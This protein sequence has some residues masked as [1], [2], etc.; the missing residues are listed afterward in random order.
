MLKG[1][2]LRKTIIGPGRRGGAVLWTHT[3]RHTHTNGWA[4]RRPGDDAE[5][6]EE[7][8]EGG[9][10]DV[11][12]VMRN[13]KNRNERSLTFITS[14]W[15]DLLFPPAFKSYLI[16]SKDCITN[17][18]TAAQRSAGSLSE[19]KGHWP[20]SA[21]MWGFIHRGTHSYTVQSRCSLNGHFGLILPI[22]YILHMCVE[23][24]GFWIDAHKN[25]WTLVVTY[26]KT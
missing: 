5:G 20:H 13:W 17:C 11:F 15:A 23:Y 19:V 9:E 18:N 25:T 6:G 12:C 8:D 3:H 14:A 26:V 22:T 2:V 16:R 10:T 21:G 4:W 1:S 7:G 24:S